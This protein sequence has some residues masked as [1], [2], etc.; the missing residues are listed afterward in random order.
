MKQFPSSKNNIFNPSK[1]KNDRN[2]WVENE[3]LAKED[4][5]ISNNIFSFEMI[6][7]IDIYDTTF[8]SVHSCPL[9]HH[10]GGSQ[11]LMKLL[12]V[13]LLNYFISKGTFQ[14]I[15]HYSRPILQESAFKDAQGIIENSSLALLYMKFSKSNVI[16][17]AMYM[18]SVWHGFALFIKQKKWIRRKKTNSWTFRDKTINEKWLRDWS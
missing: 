9:M 1:F 17:W 18:C 16:H 8:F 4:F 3:S 11:G 6:P 15:L 5:F 13:F 14:I 10:S 12:N 2:L 7:W